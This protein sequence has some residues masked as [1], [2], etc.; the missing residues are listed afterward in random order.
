[1][2]KTKSLLIF[3]YLLITSLHLQAQ[4]NIKYGENYF[5]FEAEDTSSPL[6][7]WKLRTPSD[8]LYYK[9]NDIEAFNQT[10]VEFRGAWA[11]K[12]SPLTYKFTCP[13]TGKYRMVMRLYQPLDEHE[14][15][16]ERNDVFVKMEGNYTSGTWKDKSYLETYHKLW[17]RGVRRWGACHTL[18]HGH[19]EHFPAIY[20]FTEGEEYTLTMA[21][22][23]AGAAIDYILF[24]EDTPTKQI[25]NQDLALQ[26][27]EEYRPYVKP[28]S[29][30]LSPAYTSIRVGTTIQLKTVLSPVNADPDVT[31][32]SSDEQVL[33]VDENGTVSIVGNVGQKAT[34]TATS[35]V[36]ASISASSSEIE[37]VDWYAIPV[38]SIA[39]TVD[40]TVIPEGKTAKAMANVSPFN[41]DNTSVTWSSSNESIATV[42]QNGIIT[43][44]AI[45]DATIKATSNETNTIYGEMAISVGEYIAPF[46][47]YDDRSKYENGTFVSGDKLDLVVEYHAGTNETVEDLKIMLRHMSSDWKVIKDYKPTLED[48]VGT[49]SGTI[50]ASISLDGVTPSNQLSNGEFYFLFIKATYTGGVSEDVGIQPMNI[51]AGGDGTAVASVNLDKNSLQLDNIGDT[52]QLTATVLPATAEDKSVSWISSDATVASVDANGL[53]TALKDGMTTIT[54]TTNDGSQTAQC[55][56]NV[57]EIPVQAITW[58]AQEIES[59][60]DIITD[61]TLIEAINFGGG[62]NPASYNTEVNGVSF[63]GK[64]NNLTTNTWLNPT[65]D[66]FASNSTRV[67]PSSVDIY[68]TNIGLSAFDVL[69]SNFIWDNDNGPTTITISGLTIGDEYQIQLLAADTRESQANAYVKLDDAFGDLSTTP[70]TVSNGLS[71]VGEFTAIAESFSFTYSKVDPA[72]VKGINLNAYQLRN[73]SDDVTS[74]DNVKLQPTYKVYPNPANDWIS[75]NLVDKNVTTKVSIFS[76]QGEMV[77]QDILKDNSNKVNISNF[78][79]GV[80]LIQFNTDEMVSTQKLIVR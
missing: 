80:Y 41:A 8:P 25:K 32:T 10:Y 2:K 48:Y 23:S 22:R 49:T 61:G 36:D 11:S 37:I 68:D 64:V 47:R 17:G 79:A 44:V 30:A 53:V 42:D 77:Y 43:A 7:K 31:W 27:S 45:G 76:L 74:I 66:H 38:E 35:N 72:G 70:F 20:N 57:G 65:T 59:E 56:V 3:I 54:V 71:I 33:T 55:M 24:Y 78:K 60:S 5:V 18:E 40:Q 28:E 62:D 50:N 75:I 34:I 19:G 12:E 14:R 6:G 52:Y 4:S 1:M 63:T 51:V 21:G 39:V 13:K 46:I 15:D 9:G 67:V 58:T 16:D 69:L 73:T 29:I 26:F